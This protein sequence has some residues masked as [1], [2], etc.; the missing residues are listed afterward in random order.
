MR[1]RVAG[2]GCEEADPGDP[3]GAFVLGCPEFVFRQGGGGK[4]FEDEQPVRSEGGGESGSGEEFFEQFALG[5]APGIGWIGENE[6]VARRGDAPEMRED[7]AP[8]DLATLEFG[9][10]EIFLDGLAG[11]AVGFDEIGPKRRRG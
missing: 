9:L 6:V 5:I 11:G 10:F 1:S 4:A 8:V 7:V 2:H 3:V